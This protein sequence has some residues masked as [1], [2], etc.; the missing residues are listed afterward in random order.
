MPYRGPA[1]KLRWLRL[2]AYGVLLA[3][4]ALV[5]A[6]AGFLDPDGHPLSIA[7]GRT[8]IGIFIWSTFFTFGG[9][10]MLFAFTTRRPGWEFAGLVAL[11]I[12]AGW[13]LIAAVVLLGWTGRTEAQLA[14]FIVLVVC[15]VARISALFPEQTTVVTIHGRDNGA[16]GAL[17]KNNNSSSP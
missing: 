16:N 8:I 10:A 13:Q 5:T 7:A 11:C 1:M 9:L 14:T 12:G 15:A 2:N 4:L 6:L 3:G 17:P